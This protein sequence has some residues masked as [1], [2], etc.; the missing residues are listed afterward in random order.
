MHSGIPRPFLIISS[1]PIAIIIIVCYW[2]FF[3]ISQ[4]PIWMHMLSLCWLLLSVTSTCWPHSFLIISVGEGSQWSVG[5]QIA[6]SLSHIYHHISQQH[7]LVFLQRLRVAL[8]WKRLL[9]HCVTV[10]L[11]PFCFE[12]SA[13]LAMMWRNG[14]WTL[15]FH[16]QHSR[17]VWVATTN[18]NFS[19]TSKM[20]GS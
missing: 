11:H 4:R 15:F 14:E 20:P 9:L 6:S 17:A 2:K 18:L 5:A 13:N 16:G 19:K 7:I 1:N 12:N 8:V 3:F 10:P